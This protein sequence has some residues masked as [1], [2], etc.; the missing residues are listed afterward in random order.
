MPVDQSEDVHLRRPM[1]RIVEE[2]CLP[3]IVLLS[4]ELSVRVICQICSIKAGLRATSNAAPLFA[5]KPDSGKASGQKVC[6]QEPLGPVSAN[7]CI[8]KFEC[9][10]DMGPSTGSAF[11]HWS[12]LMCLGATLLLAGLHMLFSL[13]L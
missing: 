8:L 11:Q 1:R 13:L 3:V 12:L 2:R 9:S 5:S 10:S 7:S 4:C 6:Q